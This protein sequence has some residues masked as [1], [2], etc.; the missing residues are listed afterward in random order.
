MTDAGW[1]NT[2]VLPRSRTNP[3]QTFA[4][5]RWAIAVC[6]RCGWKYKWSTL[7]TEPG[8]LLKV[9]STC[10]DGRYSMVAHPQ[11]FIATNTVDAIAL[12][13]ARPDLAPN[14]G[15]DGYPAQYATSR[16]D[17]WLLSTEDGDIIEWDQMI[18]LQMSTST[19]IDQGYGNGA[20]PPWSY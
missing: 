8:T 3:A 4:T 19:G 12:R 9:C 7:R 20:A 14:Y 18:M 11:N 17:P 10:N 5:G 2:N 15:G 16:T 1:L 13:W 6:D